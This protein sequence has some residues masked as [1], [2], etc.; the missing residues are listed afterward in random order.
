MS[1]DVRAFRCTP[2]K[3]SLRVRVYPDEVRVRKRSWS[4]GTVPTLAFVVVVLWTVSRFWN[5]FNLALAPNGPNLGQLGAAILPLLTGLVLPVA[6]VVGVAVYQFARWSANVD[7]YWQLVIQPDLWRLQGLF[8]LRTYARVEP[9]WVRDLVI[10]KDGQ[11]MA[12][13]VYGTWERVSGPQPP[14]DAAW[15]QDALAR[16]IKKGTGAPARPVQKESAPEAAIKLSEP[17][18]ESVDWPEPTAEPAHEILPPSF[19]ANEPGERL[20]YRL[21]LPPSEPN[22]A[23]SCLIVMGIFFVGIPFVWLLTLFVKLVAE[24]LG[25]PWLGGLVVLGLTGY[26]IFLGVRRRRFRRIHE[27]RLEVSEHP[28][29]AGTACRAYLFQRGPLSVTYA[30]VLLVCEEKA[31]YTD[32][33]MMRWAEEQVFT[34]ELWRGDALKLAREMPLAQEFSVKVPADA[35]HSFQS[36]NNFVTWKL[37]VEERI[38]GLWTVW[39]LEFPVLIQA[40]QV[41]ETRP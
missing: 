6:A 36:A 18:S 14:R 7:E 21:L 25:A 3:S 32:G 41:P 1:L 9:N 10:S 39:R 20:R 16:L 11:V 35:M 38:P 15:L 24:P 30:R 17:A 34:R 12:D 31:R 2:R 26:G 37:R 13:L 23:V 19:V 8:G 4:V 40:P 5:F 33:T 27:P 29:P 22:P 28:L